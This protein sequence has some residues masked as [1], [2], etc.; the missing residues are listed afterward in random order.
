M[1][2]ELN[3]DERKTYID[4]CCLLT[5]YHTNFFEKLSNCELLEEF[6]KL[7]GIEERGR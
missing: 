7:S 2:N 6:Q 4:W 1:Q 3:E 5:G